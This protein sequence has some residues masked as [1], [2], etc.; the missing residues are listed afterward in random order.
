MK[1]AQKRTTKTVTPYYGI[2]VTWAAY[3]ILF[4][5]CEPIHFVRVGLLSAGVF[6]FLWKVCECGTIEEKESAS[7][8]MDERPTGNS[9]LDQMLSDGKAM[10]LEMHSLNAHIGDQK[11]SLD[12]NHIEST[13]VKI[14]N[15]IIDNPKKLSQIRQFM[16][17]YLPTT[18][19]FLRAYE[20][21][22]ATGVSGPNI[23]STKEQIVTMIKRITT[24]FDAQLDSLFGNEALD[25]STDIAVLEAQL[26]REGLIGDKLEAEKVAD[27]SAL[28]I[29]LR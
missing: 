10:L 13:T 12:I 19:K 17:Y 4:D 29:R 3:A 22:N 26:V 23:A 6:V 8:W 7:V 18:L 27:N 28:D 16:D 14:F 1:T 25:I 20:C 9:E 15:H 21:M 5:L 24:A 2:A 11:I